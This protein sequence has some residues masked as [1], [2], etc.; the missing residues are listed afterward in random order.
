MPLKVGDRAPDFSGVTDSGENIKL[1]EK[2]KD[3]PVVLYFYPK[4]ET[5]GCT[6][7]AC[8]FRDNWENIK[9]LGATV[10]GVSSDSVE[11]HKKFKEN[12]NLPFT[13]IA[14]EKK[15]IRKAYGAT[16]ALIPPRITFVIDRDGIIREVYNSQLNATSHVE[17]A[18]KSLSSIR[19]GE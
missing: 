6:A 18:I 4:D 7:E 9:K 17:V 1:S 10:I 3:G 16:G 13:L 2:L 19:P 8:S 14:D 11:S 5:P 12:R 15:E